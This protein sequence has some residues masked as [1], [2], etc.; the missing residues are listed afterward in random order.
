[1]H[2]SK[3]LSFVTVFPEVSFQKVLHTD[4][5][6]RLCTFVSRVLFVAVK[7]ARQVS[8]GLEIFPSKVLDTNIKSERVPT[9]EVSKE[10]FTCSVTVSFDGI[11]GRVVTLAVPL[12]SSMSVIP[13]R[14]WKER[15]HSF[16]L[17]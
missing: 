3:T 15:E 11:G 1:M 17:T 13:S 7:R 14:S 2:Q 16:S 6:L 8:G 9:E 12:F 10:E 5:N 4:S